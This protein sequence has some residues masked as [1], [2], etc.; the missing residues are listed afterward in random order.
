MKAVNTLTQFED[1]S[2]VLDTPT[3]K[4]KFATISH[5]EAATGQG[6]C[7]MHYAELAFNKQEGKYIKHRGVGCGLANEILAFAGK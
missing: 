4:Y 1:G 6:G 3:T 7:L 5:S 2:M